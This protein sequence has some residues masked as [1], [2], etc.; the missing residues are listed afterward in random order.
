VVVCGLTGE[1]RYGF[2]VGGYNIFFL[3]ENGLVRIHWKAAKKAWAW[4]LRA[5]PTDSRG[6]KYKHHVRWATAAALR[7]RRSLAWFSFHDDPAMR[8]FAEANPR[9]IFRALSRYM[10]VRWGFSRRTKVIQDTYRFIALRG[11]FLA[12]AMRRPGGSILAQ[13][14]LDRGQRARIRLGSDAQFRKEGEISLFL[15]LEGV[16]GAITGTAFSVEEGSGWVALVGGFQGRKGGDEDTIKLATKAMH[17]LRPKNLMVWLLQELAQTLGIAV[18]H[19]VGN[20]VQVYRSRMNQPWVPTRD[21]RFDFDALW[22]EVGG[23]QDSDGWFRL[24]L[25]TPRRAADEI[26]PNKRSMYAK[27]YAFLDELSMQLQQRLA[28]RGGGG[29]ESLSGYQVLRD[30]PKP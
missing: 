7:P 14:D 3:L 19:G 30:L 9:L 29:P 22:E 16:A 24:P 15:E 12:E 26:K 6:R 8:G 11:G 17:G 5:Y 18:L 20:E 23:V 13:I 27:R 25:Q 1:A 21:I 10:S 28:C 4:S 2:I